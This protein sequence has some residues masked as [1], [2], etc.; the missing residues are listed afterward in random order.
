M[1]R[2]RAPGHV[3]RIAE[4]TRG[5]SG[6]PARTTARALTLTFDVLM[7]CEIADGTPLIIRPDP[8][9]PN[10]PASASRFGTISIQPPAVSGA[11]I[12]KTDTSKLSE[13]EAR[14]L[15]SSAAGN[16]ADAQ[17]TRPTTLRCS[18]TTPLGRPVDPEV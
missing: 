12:S 5:V 11:K 4:K 2:I 6:S 1:F 8:G 7:T 10:P 13:V 15:A 18:I 3:P 17:H 16:S 14:T 9:S